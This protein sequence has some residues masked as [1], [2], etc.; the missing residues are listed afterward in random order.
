MA[1]NKQKND[2]SEFDIFIANAIFPEAEP[3]FTAQLKPLAELKDTAIVILDTN[4]L[5]V[6]YNIGKESLEQIRIT[7]KKQLQQNS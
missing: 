3:L 1:E 5:L 2:G 6:P 7:C 4:A